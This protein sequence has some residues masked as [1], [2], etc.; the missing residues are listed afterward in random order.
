MDGAIMTK[1]IAFPRKGKVDAKKI[2]AQYDDEYAD[3]VDDLGGFLWH[4]RMVTRKGFDTLAPEIGVSPATLYNIANRVTK[5]PQA[6]TVW[7]ILKGLDN[8]NIIRH[9]ML[10]EY[11]PLNKKSA[12]VIRALEK[13]KA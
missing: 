4:I 3:F 12:D 8:R 13:K 7:C 11:R 2:R 10:E 1:I 9:S 5:N 6:R